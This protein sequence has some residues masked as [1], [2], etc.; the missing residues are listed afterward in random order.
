MLFGFGGKVAGYRSDMT[1]TLFVG[2]PT[3]LDLDVYELV[4][5]AQS[6]VLDGIVGAVERG[7]RLPDGRVLD[8]LAR[9]VIVEAGYGDRFED[10]L[11]ADVAARRATRLTQFPRDV[12]VVG[13]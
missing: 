7:E 6:A 4:H 11:A 10:L 3:S 8:A 5:R 1:R 12:I 9:D 13:G 2:T